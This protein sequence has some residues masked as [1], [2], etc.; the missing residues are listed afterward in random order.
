M[1]GSLLK[2]QLSHTGSPLSHTGSPL[3][4][5]RLCRVAVRKSL[6]P[7]CLA[8]PEVASLNLPPHVLTYLQSMLDMCEGETVK[9]KAV[10]GIAI[11]RPLMMET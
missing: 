10:E 8:S 3:S 4:L 5:L 1:T 6:G 11:V 9:R 2:L 7:S